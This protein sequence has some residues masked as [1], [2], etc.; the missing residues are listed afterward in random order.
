MK[1]KNS[2]K[3][4]TAFLF[5]FVLLVSMLPMSSMATAETIITKTEGTLVIQ[6][7]SDD[8]TD[9]LE[10]AVY[11][12][13]KIADIVQDTDDDGEVVMSYKSVSGL[14]NSSGNDVTVNAYTKPEDISLEQSGLTTPAK[15][16]TTTDSAEGNINNKV[17]L[18]IGIYLVVESTTP[19]NVSKANNFIVSIPMSVNEYTNDAVSGSYWN[20]DIVAEP[21]NTVMDATISKTITNGAIPDTNK[22]NSN[23]KDYWTT[24][25]G[26]TITYSIESKLPSGFTSTK[27]TTYTITDTPADMLKIDFDGDGTDDDAVDN[28]D[29]IVVTVPTSADN[30]TLITLKKDIDYEITKSSDGEGFVIELIKDSSKAGTADAYSQHLYDGAVITVIYDATFSAVA[31]AG[32]EYKN[33]V[34]IDYKYIPADETVPVAPEEPVYPPTV[35]TLTT[36]SYALQKIDSENSDP[37][38]DAS[39]V[40][41]NKEGDTYTYMTWTTA[42][43]WGTTANIDDAVVYVATSDKTADAIV[44]FE[45][46]EA[47]TYYIIETQAPDGYSLLSEPI[48]VIIGKESTNVMLSK[49]DG[50]PLYSI[51]VVNNLENSWV[52]PATGEFGIYLFT[53]GG[54]ILIAAAIILLSKNKKKNNA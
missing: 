16:I 26:E 24:S 30:D 4:I 31:V 7:T 52:L 9:Y 36:Y 15:S 10:G 2:G 21:K 47:G 1:I 41:A 27:Y 12:I 13:Y 8:K 51:Q 20:Y 22:E 14:K 43:G 18:P 6:K 11:D 50:A 37:L 45:G 35:P 39:F 33:A 49:E 46:L 17:T 5:A 29:G 42:T 53:I 28:F 32:T 25:R 23:T 54:V 44:K 3:R 34:Q 38:G 48:E 19:S 40:I